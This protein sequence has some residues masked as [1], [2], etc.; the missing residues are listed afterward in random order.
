MGQ[1]ELDAAIEVAERLAD[2]FTGRG[3]MV[4]GEFEGQIWLCSVSLALNI[5]EL[6]GATAFAEC[7]SLDQFRFVRRAPFV[8]FCLDLRTYRPEH[9]RPTGLFA[10]DAALKPLKPRKPSKI[11]TWSDHPA[12][13]RVACATT[14]AGVN[15][16]VNRDLL[17]LAGRLLP[18]TGFYANE[19]DRALQLRG[20][21]GTV[22]GYVMPIK[23]ESA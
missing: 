23:P 10:L 16:L 3:R 4:C 18:V 17:D 2:Q 13:P 5:T 12:R 14:A 19:P 22:L 9:R 8:L 7:V 15:L 20:A 21:G 1:Q 11:V 6:E